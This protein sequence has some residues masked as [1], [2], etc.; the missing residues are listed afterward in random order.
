MV[1]QKTIR[2]FLKPY[3]SQ[4]VYIVLKCTIFMKKMNIKLKDVEK[5]KINESYW[6]V[7]T[8]FFSFPNSQIGLNDLSETINSAKT[9]T[10]TAVEFLIQEGFLSKEE[11]G[12]AWRISANPKHEFLLRRKVPMNIENVYDSGIVEAVHKSIE[13]VKTIVLFGSYRWG[14]DNENSDIDIGVEIS[15]NEEPKIYEIGQINIGYR[16]NVKVNL[17]VFS[18]N[19]V[20]L[21][22]FNNIANGIVLDGFLEVRT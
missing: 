9:V 11:I 15:G 16:K 21:N 14:T 20:D 22:L 7:L 6:K 2:T 1:L 5:F 10:K 3:G 12:R 17:Y 8:Y 18:R 19:K 13:N 4:K